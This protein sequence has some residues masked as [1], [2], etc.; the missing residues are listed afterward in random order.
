MDINSLT[1]SLEA[2]LENET[3]VECHVIDLEEVNLGWETELF[4]FRSNGRGEQRNL[5]LRVFSGDQADE[6]V[7]KE[8]NLMRKL[9]EVGYPVPSVYHLDASAEVIGK[10]FIIMERV[11]GETLEA[12]YHKG[13]KEE[14][15][16]EITRL[17]RLLV[18]LHKLDISQFSKLPNLSIITIENLVGKFDVI[19][20]AHAPWLSP[21]IDWLRKNKPMTSDNYALCHNDYHGLNVILD[22]DDNPYVIDWGAA[23]IC[24]PRFDLAWT[25]LLYTTFSDP[26]FRAPIIKIYNQLDGKTDYLEYFEVLAATRRITDLVSVTSGG[27]EHGLKPEALEMMRNSRTHYIKV[28][29]FLTE[30]TGY[31]L[32][33]F[34]ELLESY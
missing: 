11:I 13:S 34:D 6:K 20:K 18:D 16:E 10:P 30:R 31:R 3:G 12:S 24:D 2:Y 1:Q 17:I 33:E 8:Y 28:H 21:V 23:G 15:E 9:G 29:D 25:I 32:K 4:T 22:K 14:M 27:S 19:S 7:V 5:V 26:L